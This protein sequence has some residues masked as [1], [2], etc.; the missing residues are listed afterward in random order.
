MWDFH[1]FLYQ[2]YHFGKYF[3]IHFL[4]I[5]SKWVYYGYLVAE[6]NPFYTWF[7]AFDKQDSLKKLD[8]NHLNL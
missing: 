7:N 5:L 6:E 2:W 8:Q 1:I 3:L 4:S